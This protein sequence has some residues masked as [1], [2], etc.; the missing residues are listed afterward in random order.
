[1]PLYDPVYALIWPSPTVIS[2]EDD[3]W[4]PGTVARLFLVSLSSLSTKAVRDLCEK[5]LHQI[6]NFQHNQWW[7]LQKRW[8]RGPCVRKWLWLWGEWRRTSVHKRADL[9]ALQ[10]TSERG[11][12]FHHVS[13]NEVSLC[14]REQ[15]CFK[16]FP[17]GHA[18]VLQRALLPFR[19]R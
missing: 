19:R 1:M 5:K 16:P 13:V 11:C 2:G 9:T 3:S 18:K 4:A 7:A 8:Q 17:E 6:I 10:A 14:T 12:A 15:S